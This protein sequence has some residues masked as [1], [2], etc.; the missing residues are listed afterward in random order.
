[1]VPI[2]ITIHE[3]RKNFQRISM[4]AKYGQSFLVTK[5]NEPVFK[6]EPPEP[7]IEK[8]KYTMKDFSKIQ[9]NGD[10]NLS[11]DIDKILYSE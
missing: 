5:Y 8:P 6:I 11:R 10:K 1:M 9:F 3:F 7:L 4:Q 2:T